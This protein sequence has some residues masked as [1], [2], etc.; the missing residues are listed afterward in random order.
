VSD[1]LV[2]QLTDILITRVLG[3]APRA[4]ITRNTALLSSGLGLD[5][6]AVLELVIAAESHFGV[7]FQDS[8]LSVDLFRSVGSFADAIDQKLGDGRVGKADAP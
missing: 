2:T 5:S 1:A 3:T 7:E 8:D 4:P 6:V